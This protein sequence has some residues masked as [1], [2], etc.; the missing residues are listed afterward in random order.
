MQFPIIWWLGGIAVAASIAIALAVRSRRARISGMRPN[1]RL[2]SQRIDGRKTP[3]GNYT[4]I[5]KAQTVQHYLAN[6]APPLP[7]LLGQSDRDSMEAL[8]RYFARA[9]PTP[10]KDSRVFVMDTLGH[11]GPQLELFVPVLSSKSPIAVLARSWDVTSQTLDP[12]IF[13]F[14]VVNPAVLAIV[15]KLGFET[16]DESTDKT[17]MVF[18]NRKQASRRR[19]G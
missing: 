18:R 16:H 14:G 9:I 5:L 12:T 6:G 13:F 1:I 15:A 3:F 4:S 7:W 19:A 17:M 11:G 8:S 2:M 10:D